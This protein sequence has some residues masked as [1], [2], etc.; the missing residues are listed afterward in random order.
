MKKIYISIH[1]KGLVGREGVGEEEEGKG[2]YSLCVRG[3][4][5]N[6]A[7][8]GARVRESCRKLRN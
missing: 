2:S 8:V 6:N 5:N 1:I 3:G 7:D 4:K